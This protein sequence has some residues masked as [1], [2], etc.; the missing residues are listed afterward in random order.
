M[1]H[2]AS[3]RQWPGSD[4][5]PK[6]YTSSPA[7]EKDWGQGQYQRLLLTSSVAGH[8]QTMAAPSAI[9][10]QRETR[11][12]D[13]AASRENGSKMATGAEAAGRLSQERFQR[14]RAFG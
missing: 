7:E 1:K 12:P 14:L 2:Q 13:H 6:A 5:V 4:G 3:R 11:G 9:L 8:H 10:P